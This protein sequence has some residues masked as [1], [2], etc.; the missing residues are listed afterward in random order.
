ME[1]AT[2]FIGLDMHEATIAVAN[3]DG[4]CRYAAR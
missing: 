1:R 3:A 2:T 4:G